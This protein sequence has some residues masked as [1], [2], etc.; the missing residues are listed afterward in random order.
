MLALEIDYQITRIEIL[1]QHV[2]NM[3]VKKRWNKITLAG[4]LSDELKKTQASLKNCKINDYKR[5]RKM[6]QKINEIEKQIPYYVRKSVQKDII[7]IPEENCEKI[8]IELAHNR[9][10]SE[11]KQFEKIHFSESE[12]SVNAAQ[13]KISKI[14][15]RLE[16]LSDGKVAQVN[17]MEK[18]ENTLQKISENFAENPEILEE[19]QQMLQIL[20]TLK[21]QDWQKTHQISQNTQ[22]KVATIVSE[23]TIE[24]TENLEIPEKYQK[25]LEDLFSKDGIHHSASNTKNPTLHSMGDGSFAN[26]I[27]RPILNFTKKLLEQWLIHPEK[28]SWK[29]IA[30]YYFQKHQ[31]SDIGHNTFFKILQK[32]D[33]QGDF[34]EIFDFF[35]LAIIDLREVNFLKNPHTDNYKTIIER[36]EKIIQKHKNIA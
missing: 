35:I 26:K 17:E 32:Y 6:I 16:N 20:A 23:N 2:D 34:I 7:E 4:K 11:E 19:I 22:K 3:W 13:Q 25:F 10:N 1:Q 5:I 24:A 28:T 12:H 14:L 8:L 29:E 18:M 21:Q 31:T 36:I 30:D 33:T 15:G 27:G 9:K